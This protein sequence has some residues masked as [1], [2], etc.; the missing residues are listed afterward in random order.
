LAMPS[1]DFLCLDCKQLCVDV[2][3][4]IDNRKFVKCE[5]CGSSNIEQQILVAPAICSSFEVM[6]E[7][8][9]NYDAPNVQDS[10]PDA[11]LK[12]CSSFQSKGRG[13]LVDSGHVKSVNF[14]SDRDQIGVEITGGIFDAEGTEIT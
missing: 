8:V 9:N 2:F 14:K 5:F 11:V 13:L 6:H 3:C 7:P 1:Y 4:K 10:F 12:N